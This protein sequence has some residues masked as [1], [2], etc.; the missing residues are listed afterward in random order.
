[1]KL[2]SGGFAIVSYRATAGAPFQV[3]VD[4]EPGTNVQVQLPDGQ[5]SS[6]ATTGGIGFA[7][8][9]GTYRLSV[10]GAAGHTASMTMSPLT[11]IPTVTLGQS[12]VVH[13]AS[14][15]ANQAVRITIQAGQKVRP[16]VS[17]GG[18]IDMYTTVGRPSYDDTYTTKQASATYYGIVGFRSDSLLFG[19]TESDT[20]TQPTFP[21][22]V[23]VTAADASTTAAFEGTSSETVTTDLQASKHQSDD[24]DE[25]SFDPSEDEEYLA[26]PAGLTSTLHLALTPSLQAKVS[27]DC[28]ANGDGTD[29]SDD[30]DVPVIDPDSDLSGS[31][32]W[33]G[34]DTPG[35]SVDVPI[36]ATTSDQECNVTVH[37][38]AGSGTMT[39]SVT[40]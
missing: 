30:S 13:I 19:G 2:N 17:G 24:D 18:G 14:A 38:V 20:T 25:F 27:V 22:D 36:P 16:Q 28:S 4:G 33:T 35:Q 23:T 29:G 15:S 1:V 5:Q 3:R 39:L 40:H 26:V 11:D 31:P 34:G 10:T 6:L 8:V 7:P 9:D 32:A 21:V 37:P 12:T